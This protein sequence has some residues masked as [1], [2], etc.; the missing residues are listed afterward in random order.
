MKMRLG[1][2]EAYSYPNSVRGHERSLSGDRRSDGINRTVEND[3]EAVPLG[4]DFVPTMSL[5]RFAEQTAMLGAEVA[6]PGTVSA[7]KFSRALDVAEQEGDCPARQASTHTERCYA[8]TAN[9]GNVA[10]MR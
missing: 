5:H 4:I 10:P 8:G 7:R 9:A 3:E 2:M 1:G 6:V